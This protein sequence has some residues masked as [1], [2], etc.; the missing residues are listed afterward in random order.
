MASISILLIAA[1]VQVDTTSASLSWDAV[2]GATGY[3]VTHTRPENDFLTG[4]VTQRT[5]LPATTSEP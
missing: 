1:V 3:T 4:R 5:T 2:E